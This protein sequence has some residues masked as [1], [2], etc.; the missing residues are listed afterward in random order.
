[1]NGKDL[2]N[3]AK[4]AGIS[5]RTLYRA[6]KRIGVQTEGGGFGKPRIWSMSAK[7]PHVCQSPDVG[8][9]GT[10]GTHGSESEKPE[11]RERVEL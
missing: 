8:T 9:H 5:E 3:M 6:A 11:P 10:D 7:N 4:N 1:M 2:K